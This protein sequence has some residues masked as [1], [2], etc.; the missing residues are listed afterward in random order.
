MGSLEKLSGPPNRVLTFA[1]LLIFWEPEHKTR[2]HHSP[3]LPGGPIMRPCLLSTADGDLDR[4]PAATAI[5]SHMSAP[6]FESSDFSEPPRG[7][8]GRRRKR[9]RAT[10]E[11]LG[12]GFSWGAEPEGTKAEASRHRWGLIVLGSA[13]FVLFCGLSYVAY[14]WYREYAQQASPKPTSPKRSL[15]ITPAIPEDT[16]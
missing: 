13:C 10:A 4:F 15:L 7:R 11:Q 3:P 12:R 16:R 14:Q 1:C 2:R 9:R 6:S 5:P 8:S